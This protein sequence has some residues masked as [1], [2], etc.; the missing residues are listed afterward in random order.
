MCSAASVTRRCLPRRL[1]ADASAGSTWHKLDSK[2]TLV[3][4][5]R[6]RDPVVDIVLSRTVSLI[7]G[8]FIEMLGSAVVMQN[9]QSR[10]LETVALHLSMG[11]VQEGPADA[12]A[13][14]IWRNV[15]GV[16]LTDTARTRYLTATRPKADPPRRATVTERHKI[17]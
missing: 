11:L 16:D 8:P 7:A 15:Q 4:E 3:A 17:S 12:L 5:F 9:P 1:K 13:G 6:E 10:S 2:H 14:Q